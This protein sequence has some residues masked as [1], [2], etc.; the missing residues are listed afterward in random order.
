VVWFLLGEAAVT[1]IV[2]A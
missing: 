2:T 1:C